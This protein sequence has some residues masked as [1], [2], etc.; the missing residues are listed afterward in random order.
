MGSGHV[1]TCAKFPSLYRQ[2]CEEE[3][4]ISKTKG[5]SAFF[6]SCFCVSLKELAA[7]N[8]NNRAYDH[9]FPIFFC[10]PRSPSRKVITSRRGISSRVQRVCSGGHRTALVT[11][12]FSGHLFHLQRPSKLL[13]YCAKLGVDPRNFAQEIGTGPVRENPP[14][15]LPRK[16]FI[17]PPAKVPSESAV[18]PARHHPPAPDL[19]LDYFHQFPFH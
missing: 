7:E 11:V 9:N 15:S 17:P 1:H 16:V 5:G 12:Q 6:R 3:I 8:S 4:V 18:H 19:K 14:P 2:S 10:Q 13:E